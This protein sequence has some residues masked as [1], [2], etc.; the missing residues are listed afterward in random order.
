MSHLVLCVFFVCTFLLKPDEKDEAAMDKSTDC[1]RLIYAFSDAD[2]FQVFLFFSPS[3]CLD[4][5]FGV[6]YVT[7]KKNELNAK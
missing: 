5:R 2:I 1:E 4:A 6:L 7:R 3:S